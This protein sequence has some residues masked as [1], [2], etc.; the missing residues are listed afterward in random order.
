MCACSYPRCFGEK[1]VSAYELSKGALTCMRA[2][3]LMLTVLMVANGA[4]VATSEQSKQRS[5]YLGK[6]QW[7]NKMMLKKRKQ[8]CQSASKNS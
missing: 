5:H 8:C 3:M 4:Q 7:Y 6:D 2:C 1:L